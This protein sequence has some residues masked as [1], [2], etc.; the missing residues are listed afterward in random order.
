MERGYTPK[1][2]PISHGCAPSF[3]RVRFLDP[4]LFSLCHLGFS[5][6]KIPSY[7]QYDWIPNY[8]KKEKKEGKCRTLI[9]FDK[10]KFCQLF[11]GKIFT[12][13]GDSLSHS[14]YGDLIN[15]LGGVGGGHTCKGRKEFSVILRSQGW[16]CAPKGNGITLRVI[17]ND[18]LRPDLWTP[19]IH[20]SEAL[21]NHSK[22]LEY[23]FNKMNETRDFQPAPKI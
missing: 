15:L 19:Y 20:S 1:C 8:P 2:L 22:V 23:F 3:Q 17:R 6:E 7:S 11:A 16:A 13:I 21:K 10:Q 12:F 9:P 14:H 4:F 5:F 18:W